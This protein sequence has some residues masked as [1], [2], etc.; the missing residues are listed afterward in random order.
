MIFRPH[1]AAIKISSHGV[2]MKKLSLFISLFFV[3]TDTVSAYTANEINSYIKRK[4][5]ND[6]LGRQF[7]IKPLDKCTILIRTEQDKYYH[8]IKLGA[9]DLGKLNN[10][11]FSELYEVLHYGVYINLAKHPESP[12]KSFI[13]FPKDIKIPKAGLPSE[14]YYSDNYEIIVRDIDTATRIAKGFSSLAQSCGAKK[15]MF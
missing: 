5:K 7:V 15:E 12:D 13:N 2:P 9:L 8:R 1:I 6:G 14:F 4:L 11:R 10:L 3:L